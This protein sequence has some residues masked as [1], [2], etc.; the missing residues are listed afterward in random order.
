MTPQRA[1]LPWILSIGGAGTQ[2]TL[3][4]SASNSS[5]RING[6]EVNDPCPISVAG[7]MIEISPL[8]AMLT[9]GLKGV[10]TASPSGARVA[11]AASGAAVAARA[12]LSAPTV[13]A[14]VSPPIPTMKPRRETPVFGS[15]IRFMAHP[16]PR[17]VRSRAEW[18]H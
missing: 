10:P 7:A 17:R 18:P 1:G 8:G 4:Q 11:P 15:V 5:A 3:D 6:S 13:K 12:D 2:T 9:H 14:N 16:H